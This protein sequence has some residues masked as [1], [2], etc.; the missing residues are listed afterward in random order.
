MV[1]N[2]A[3][4]GPGEGVKYKNYSLVDVGASWRINKHHKLALAVNNVLDKDTVLWVEKEG[5]SGVA[6][7]YRQYLDGRNLWLSYTYDF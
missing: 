6:N 3:K 7:A 2:T 5:G 4:S 1:S